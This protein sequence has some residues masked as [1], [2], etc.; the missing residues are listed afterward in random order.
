[1]RLRLAFKLHGDEAELARQISDAA[2]VDVDKLA[3]LAMQRYMD[4]I[5]KRATEAQKKEA[6]DDRLQPS[7]SDPVLLDGTVP[8]SSDAVS[9]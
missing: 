6:N 5:I 1:V 2:G 3:K 7:S 4:D 9:G 8:P